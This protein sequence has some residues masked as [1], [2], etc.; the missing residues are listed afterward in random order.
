MAPISADPL[1]QPYRLKHLT[2]R[3]RV[4]STSHEP[5]YTVDGMPKERYR[6]YHVEKAR[7]GIAMTM[8]GGSAVVAPDSPQAFGNIL[9]YTD[10]AV[11]WLRELADE[12]HEHGAAVMI[13]ITHLGRRTVWHKDDWLPIVAP[14][15][16]R[17]PAHR[18]FPKA[19]EDWDIARIV[20]AYASAAERVKA[21]G[22][23]GLELEMYGHL[24]DQFW[25]PATNRR[26][27]EYGG[28]LDN[29]LRFAFQVMQAVRARVGP[30]FIVGARMVC[31][32]NWDRGLGREEG[33]E[34]ARR[35]AGS[36]LIDFINVIRGHIDSDEGLSH[37][38]PGMGYRLAPHLDF[39]G[40]VR[41]ATRFP[42]LHASR[43]QDVATARHAIAS[44]KLDLVGMTRAHMADPHIV[45]KVMEGREHEII[46]CVGMGYCI[47]RI[48]FGGDALCIHNAATGRELTMPHIIERSYGPK[49]KV[50]VVGAGP[51]GLEAARVASARGHEV[52]VF[53]AAGEP[54]G[55]IRV[56]AGL[57][58]RR[59]ILGIVEW[60]VTQCEAHGVNFR[61]NT[62]AEAHDIIAESPDIVVIATGGVPNT[63]FLDAGD[64]LICSGWDI[65][66]GAVRPA[67][68]VLLYDDNGAHP[69]MTAAEFVA[70]TG[71]K[72]EIVTPERILAPDVGGTNY[73]VYFR[74]FAKHGV[75]I[76][77]NQR[78]TTV[79][80]EGNT[81]V[82]ALFD[83]YGR[84]TSER[85]VDQ[86]VVEHGTLP[87]DEVYF[88]LKPQS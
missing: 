87:L 79:A 84:S 48:Y 27:D 39:A 23:D 57:K 81:L 80:R 26:D 41:A 42:I 13:Q 59:E 73:P 75:R 66:T 86:V 28:S 76:T 68:N 31:D 53:D 70:E 50:V 64:H 74:A 25:S 29:R 12:V 44:G 7:G 72:L 46:P 55:Q 82:A 33:I 58:R 43:I 69:G 11:R 52:T 56:T 9:L 51:A 47:D 61:Y 65:L 15:P 37:V 10:E 5:A 38:I 18:A 77:L 35:F 17:E 3:N 36:G 49:K 83:E 21:A 40:E 71:A 45:R 88:A 62:Y 8:I 85:R 6:R 78:L 30:E 54:G 24:I 2:L 60:R 32:E 20:E 67:E 63:S 4:I 16:V 19:I 22:L 34:I 1:L 14:S